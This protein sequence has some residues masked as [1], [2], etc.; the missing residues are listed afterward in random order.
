MRSA[1][2]PQRREALAGMAVLVAAIALSWAL[3]A[4]L[5]VALV[6][7]DI[8]LGAAVGGAIVAIC[9]VTLISGERLHH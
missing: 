2:S 5:V 3:C 9:A 6:A 8:A 7:G 4:A 1:R